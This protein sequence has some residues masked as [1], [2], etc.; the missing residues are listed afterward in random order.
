M[1]QTASPPASMGSL[2]SGGGGG[3]SPSGGSPSS[4]PQPMVVSNNMGAN[5]NQSQQ[6]QSRDNG[7]GDQTIIS[8][9]ESQ[10]DALLNQKYQ[11]LPKKHPNLLLNRR[12]TKSYFDSGDYHMARAKQPVSTAS[13]PG[14][15]S[16][17][18]NG[19]SNNSSPNSNHPPTIQTLPPPPVLQ[20]PTTGVVTI[21]G[22]NTSPIIPSIP[23]TPETVELKRHPP[24]RRQSKLI[25]SSTN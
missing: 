8:E 9:S 3:G 1:A 2:S 11:N 15:Q 23:A 20:A 10:Q 4:S 6:Q 14:G 12:N 16:P 22:L 17:D 19:G 24:E 5:T 18:S 13:S 21:G 7:R 25:E